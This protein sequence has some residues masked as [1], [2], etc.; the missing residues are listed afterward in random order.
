MIVVSSLKELVDKHGVRRL[1]VACGVFDGLHRGH[2]AIIKR[3]VA[4]AESTDAVAGVITF[5]PHPRAIINK[6]PPPSLS[7]REQQL[8]MFG[9]LGVQAVAIVPF[10]QQIAALSAD[11]FLDLEMLVDGV[12]LTGIC[13]GSTWRFGAGGK[14]TTATLERWG[15][16]HGFHVVSVPELDW[17]GRPIS[18]TRIRE[19]VAEANLDKAKR[20][21]GRPYSVRGK[22]ASGRG[23]GKKQLACPTAN[24]N[25]T[26][27]V[28]PPPGVYAATLIVN[29]QKT[30]IGQAE[31][32]AGIV[33]IGTAATMENPH[34]KPVLECHLF[35]FNRDIYGQDIEVQFRQFIRRDKRFSSPAALSAQIQKDLAA[36]KSILEE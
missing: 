4:L 2:Q 17:Y 9:Q 19:A 32:H 28:L 23:I 12:E 30:N 15:E 27:I 26:N 34:E 14:G 36:A 35:D 21:L 18:S 20:M 7:E 3:L 29:P 22:V 13:V 8:E 24:L 5:S 6:K 11:D 31:K 25:L 10:N 33:Y 16:I 1:A